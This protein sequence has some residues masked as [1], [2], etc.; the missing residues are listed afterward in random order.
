MN[1]WDHER[2]QHGRGMIALFFSYL[3][4]FFQN[5]QPAEGKRDTEWECGG[6]RVKLS[7]LYCISRF[8]S[9]LVLTLV[10]WNKAH[11]TSPP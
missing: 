3:C 8:S 5:P 7:T 4:L 10:S 11:H 2:V 9:L 6:E 1:G